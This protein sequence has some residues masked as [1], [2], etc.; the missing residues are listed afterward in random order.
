MRSVR[1]IWFELIYLRRKGEKNWHNFKN[2]FF[3]DKE[4]YDYVILEL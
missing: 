2:I 3:Y 1:V 4:I